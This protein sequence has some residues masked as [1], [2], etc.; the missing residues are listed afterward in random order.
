MNTKHIARNIALIVTFGV[1]ASANA[2]LL[3]GS[4]GGSAGGS[5]GGSAGGSLG[6]SLGGITRG[7]SNIGAQLGG[8]AD[9]MGSLAGRGALMNEARARRSLDAAGSAGA[10]GSGAANVAPPRASFD[11]SGSASGSAGARIETGLVRN[12]AGAL[13]AQGAS[14]RGFARSSVN[15]VRGAAQLVN[16]NGSA[17]VDARADANTSAEN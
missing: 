15:N 11:G 1:A 10:E 16:V 9:A 5:L 2:Q 6:G 7:T 12:T 13:R 8:Q 4:L 3:G 17:S 14:A